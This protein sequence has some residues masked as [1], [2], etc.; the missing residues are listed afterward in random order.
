LVSVEMAQKQA[1]VYFF[2]HDDMCVFTIGVLYIIIY[3]IITLHYH[4]VCICSCLL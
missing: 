3:V 4:V 2:Y 1:L